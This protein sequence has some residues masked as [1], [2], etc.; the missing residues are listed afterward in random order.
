MCQIGVE[1]HQCACTNVP[2]NVPGA[3][4]LETCT[5]RTL[6]GGRAVWERKHTA[7][8]IFLIGAFMLSTV[9]TLPGILVLR[10][11][12]VSTLRISV[13]R[14]ASVMTC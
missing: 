10:L 7:Y 5:R 4:F 6:G 11:S 8:S 1:E 3:L 13:L 9:S 14:L 2:G 12:S